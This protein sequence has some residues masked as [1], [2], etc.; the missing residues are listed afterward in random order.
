MRFVPVKLKVRQEDPD[1]P[2]KFI[3]SDFASHPGVGVSR[4]SA[5]FRGWL[6]VP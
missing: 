1:A 2:D 3:A 5:A 4:G 6:D